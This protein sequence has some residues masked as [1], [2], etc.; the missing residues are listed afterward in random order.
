MS[1]LTANK[2]YVLTCSGAGGSANDSAD[3]T[4]GHARADGDSHGVADE[5]RLRRQL[6]AHVVEHERDELH[7]VG[8]L[9]RQQVAVGQSGDEQPHGEQALRAHLHRARAAATTTAPT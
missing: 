8:R 2:H 3:V 6:D 9:V 5:R 1:N 7:G 4:I